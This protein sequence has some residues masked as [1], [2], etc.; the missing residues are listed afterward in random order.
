MIYNLSVKIKAPVLVNIVIDYINDC[1]VSRV[2][3]MQ[4]NFSFFSFRQS[5][6]DVA[7]YTILLILTLNNTI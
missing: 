7:S 2:A 6:V 4:G 5:I 3:E 1:A